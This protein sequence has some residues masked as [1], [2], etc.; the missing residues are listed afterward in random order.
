MYKEGVNKTEK[1]K[2]SYKERSPDVQRLFE[3]KK[4]RMVAPTAHFTLI[5]P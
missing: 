5:S 3:E 4:I 1:M 2:K